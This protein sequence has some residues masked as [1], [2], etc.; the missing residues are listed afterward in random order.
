MA[1]E[2][3]TKPSNEQAAGASWWTGRSQPGSRRRNPQ[4]LQKLGDT[5][6]LRESQAQDSRPART[7]LE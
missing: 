4:G 6:S 2:R 3:R 7:S 1:I 5:F